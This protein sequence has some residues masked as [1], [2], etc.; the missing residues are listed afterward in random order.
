MAV[1]EIGISGFVLHNSYGPWLQ[2]VWREPENT[3]QL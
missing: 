1:T 3:M 2:L